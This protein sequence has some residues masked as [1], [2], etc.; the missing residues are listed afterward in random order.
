MRSSLLGAAAVAAVAAAQAPP[1]DHAGLA[2]G[3]VRDITWGALSTTNGNRTAGSRPGD[4][5]V[6]PYAFADVAGQPYLYGSDLD[7]S[8]QDLFHGHSARASLAL[9]Q[10]A[11]RN[12]SACEIG[13]GEFSD[14]ENPPCA[15]LVI[16]GTVSKVVSGSDEDTRAKAALFA[17][18]PSFRKLPASHGFFVA[19]LEL[20]GIWMIDFY[21]GAKIIA[22]VDYFAA[23]PHNHIMGTT[24]A[25]TPT[26]SP[27]PPNP[28]AASEKIATAR[29]MARWLD[30]GHI[31]TTSTRSQGTSVGTAF[32]N[33]YSF[34]DV[35]GQP[36]LYASDM[37]GSMVD[38][39][40]GNGTSAPPRA[41]A[42]F[43]LSE[44]SV[45]GPELATC[46]IGA[47]E[48]SDPES[49]PCARLVLSGAVS[50]VVAG[51]HEDARAKAALFARHPSF[52]N[53]PASH[54]FFVAKLELDGI[55]L[56]DM[57]GGAAIIDPTAYFENA[58]TTAP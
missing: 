38:L 11:L 53:L 9:S 10:A 44:A 54:G 51:S 47:S 37:D 39:F 23:T 18:H 4:P 26:P 21:G 6:N 46:R 20:D 13:A 7:A 35:D 50:K 31:A 30:Y 43:A 16:S 17:R 3:M 25:E 33:P 41:R 58:T 27:P 22:P 12:V 57:F 56:I 45:P 28:P 15:R 36:Y 52:K 29:W 2:R 24:A 1:A 42:S 48:Y 55:W 19:K 5:F 8:F 34:A 40:V 14:P 49:P 32:G